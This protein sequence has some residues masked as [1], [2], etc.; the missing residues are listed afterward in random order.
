[1]A[2]SKKPLVPHHLV[3]PGDREDSV[4]RP[5]DAAVTSVRPRQES[6][7]ELRPSVPASIRTHS[8]TRPVASARPPAPGSL[9]AR[10]EQKLRIA[11]AL[12]QNLPLSDTRVR[13]LSVAIM[14]RDEALL[15]GV[16][17]ELNKPVS[18]R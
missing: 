6:Q 9:D 14:R 5:L 4:I 11:T 15:D 13:L 12:V 16:L 8:G 18:G 7:P 1:M 2:A 17:A 3:A 10:L